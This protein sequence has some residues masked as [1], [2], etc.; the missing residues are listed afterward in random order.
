MKNTAITVYID[1]KPHL[2]T[3]FGWLYRSW[4]YSGSNKT[5]DIVA[6]HHPDIESLPKD[7]GVIYIPHKPLTESSLMWSKYP[8]INSIWYLTQPEAE[9]LVGYKYLMRTDTDVFLTPNFPNLQPRLA[10]F[11]IGMFADTPAVVT[12]LAAV[13]ERWG[14]QPSLN[15]I[16]STFMAYSNHALQY[17]RLHYEYCEKLVREEFHESDGAWPGWYIG[18][19][20]MYA[21]QLAALKYFGA[22]LT[23]GGL[24]V[25]C[26][27]QDQMCSTD[28]HIHAWH[29]WQYFSKFK[30][31]KG[32][33]RDYDM[34]KL[35]KNCIADYCL[36]IAGPGP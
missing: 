12:R 19:L 35:D 28:Y 20:T 33:Y 2:V 3:E 23:M 24:D 6:F 25:H 27:S 17:N 4:L 10:V 5:S 18:V 31:R 34:D 7:D 32:E 16:G 36:W 13:A 29:T 22:G 21:G 14:I 8:F 11:G 30:W 15:N 9:F 26:M 1:N